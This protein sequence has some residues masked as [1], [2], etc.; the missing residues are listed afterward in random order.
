MRLAGVYTGKM[1]KSMGCKALDR[2]LEDARAGRAAQGQRNFFAF[3]THG[4]FV[5]CA[6]RRK[7]NTFLTREQRP[8]GQFSEDS[9]Q[10]L[11][12]KLP[13]ASCRYLFFGV[14][15]AILDSYHRGY[16]S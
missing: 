3:D 4:D 8:L 16:E 14:D 15:I 1:K 10:F 9:G 5:L 12:V 2:R 7:A 6:S 13:V 11:R